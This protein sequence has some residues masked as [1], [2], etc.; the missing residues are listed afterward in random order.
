MAKI[1]FQRAQDTSRE[2]YHIGYDGRDMLG[3]V[4][5][6]QDE[7]HSDFRFNGKDFELRSASL[8]EAKDAVRTAIKA[9]EK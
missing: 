3:Y 4:V 2:R 5:F 7:W 1:D 6:F 8:D 9:E